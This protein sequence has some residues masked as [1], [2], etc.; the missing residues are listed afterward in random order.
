[1]K[2]S[3]IEQALR[4][5]K[6]FKNFEGPVIKKN[7]KLGRIRSLKAGEYVFRQGDFHLLRY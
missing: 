7:S 5:C 6:F 4:E 3:D 2:V 1:M